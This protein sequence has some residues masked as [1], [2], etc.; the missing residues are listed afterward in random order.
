[1]SGQI[2]LLTDGKSRN[3]LGPFNRTGVRL[4]YTSTRRNGKDTDLYTIDPRDPRSDRLLAQVEGGGWTPLDWSP[5]GTHLLVQEYLS[6]NESYLWLFETTTGAR[7]LVTPKG[8]G[9]KVS[10][11][12][13]A[14]TSDGRA[15]FTATDKD[16]EFRRLAR[17]ELASKE[18][19][20]ITA[21]I[22]W[23]V[24]DFSA[25]RDGTSLAV[26]TNEEGAGVLHLFAAAT[27]NERPRPQL[28]P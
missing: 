25:S 4:A 7:E 10:Y 16:S 13:G 26:V 24:D 27:G 21:A 11:S 12:G 9:E 1:P 28:P 5:D 14:F 22:P 20:F 6:V 18:H 15:L 2:T 8:G 17:V 19:R 3:N 23:D